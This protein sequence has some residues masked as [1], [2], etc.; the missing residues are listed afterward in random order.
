M[1]ATRKVRLLRQWRHCKAGF[2]MEV[3]PGEADIYVN[4]KKP[5]LAEYVT[6]PAPQQPA[7]R[8]KEKGKV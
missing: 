2:V 4:R 8:A 1:G 3:S 5:P 6:D 7:R